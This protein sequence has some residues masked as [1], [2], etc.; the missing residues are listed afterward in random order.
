[1]E[2]TD[3]KDLLGLRQ[4]SQPFQ[5]VPVLVLLPKILNKQFLKHMII[6]FRNIRAMLLSL[7]GLK[8]PKLLAVVSNLKPALLANRTPC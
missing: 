7:P 3:R 6:R 4:P 2:R 5:K 8:L 1:M